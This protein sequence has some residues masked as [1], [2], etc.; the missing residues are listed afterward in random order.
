MMARRFTVGPCQAKKPYDYRRPQSPEKDRGSR[1]SRR[2]PSRSVSFDSGNGP[3]SEVSNQ[4]L[5][6]ILAL[7]ALFPYIS[8]LSPKSNA[9]GYPND[10]V[11]NPIAFSVVYGFIEL[12]PS[13][14]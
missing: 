8:D 1:R 6:V 4:N 9:I 14:F 13:V 11:L 12:S 5:S 7:S 2:G 10:T 3:G